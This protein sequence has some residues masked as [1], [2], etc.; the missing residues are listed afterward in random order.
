MFVIGS[1]ELSGALVAL[2]EAP[3]GSKTPHLPTNPAF[4]RA[5]EAPGSLLEATWLEVVQ[6]HSKS[7]FEVARKHRTCR[8]IRASR[9]LGSELRR[10][11]P[12]HLPTNPAFAR[13][14]Y[15]K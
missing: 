7:L 15:S 14:K 12:P 10:S 9:S 11:K 4:A 3:L 6:N 1:S 8:Q 5:F 13:L 2:L